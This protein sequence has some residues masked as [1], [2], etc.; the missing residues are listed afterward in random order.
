[1]PA[2]DFLAFIL[3]ACLFGILGCSFLTHNF[4]CKG[5]LFT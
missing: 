3:L 2:N 5:G 1:M 4:K